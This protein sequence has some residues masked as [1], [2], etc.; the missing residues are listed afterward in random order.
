MRHP[1]IQVVDMGAGKS[2]FWF[3]KAGWLKSKSFL[4]YDYAGEERMLTKQGKEIQKA[5]SEDFQEI[6]GKR[7]LLVQEK[8]DDPKVL[9]PICRTILSE[10][11]KAII[12][13][14]APAD[15]RDASVKIMQRTEQETSNKFSQLLTQALPFI[16]V[17]G[18]IVCLIFIIQYAKHSQAES[19]SQTIEAIKLAYQNK[20][21]I[22]ASSTAP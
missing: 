20:G 16:K 14:I 21:A 13:T 10:K 22:I 5:T 7:G 8:S 1:V 12:N 3:T 2:S 17:G 15:F 11:G 4:G 6:N 9:V 19:W 18:F